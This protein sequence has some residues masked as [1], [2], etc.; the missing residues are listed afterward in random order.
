MFFSVDAANTFQLLVEVWYRNFLPWHT[1]RSQ[2]IGQKVWL[3]DAVP[4]LSVI[5]FIL[6]TRSPDV[7]SRLTSCSSS[8]QQV[9]FQMTCLL[10]VFCHCAISEHSCCVSFFFLFLFMASCTPTPEDVYSISELRSFA[11]ISAAVA[12][13]AKLNASKLTRHFSRTT[14]APFSLALIVAELPPR[15]SVPYDW[16]TAPAP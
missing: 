15:L 3:Y 1:R 11:T 8:N 5:V 16:S 7:S 10:S 2:L 4:L 9:H 6:R 14:N 12:A 13:V